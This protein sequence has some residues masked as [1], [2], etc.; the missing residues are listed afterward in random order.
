M[1]SAVIFGDPRDDLRGQLGI[2]SGLEVGPGQAADET[3]PS[4]VLLGRQAQRRERLI[5]RS[6]QGEAAARRAEVQPSL[7]RDGD[8]PVPLDHDSL[9]HTAA[10]KP[11]KQTN[12]AS[13][14][15]ARAASGSRE[16]LVGA[17]E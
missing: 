10:S 17:H 14:S 11:P 1:S 7:G 8:E 12:T 5:E 13:G 4:L 3:L 15:A 6:G 2:G 9:A 16:G